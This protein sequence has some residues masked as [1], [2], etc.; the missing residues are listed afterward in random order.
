MAVLKS[1]PFCGGKVKIIPEQVDARTVT[2]NF[3][4]QNGDC[5]ANVYFDYSDRE[6]SIE[7]WN[8]RKPMEDVVAELEELADNAK[9][10]CDE[11]DFF[12]G[13]VHAYEYAIEIVRGKE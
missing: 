8:T 13:K 6:E 12:V 3:V 7:E 11:D 2:Y 10:L 1:C 5:G 9:V 4:C